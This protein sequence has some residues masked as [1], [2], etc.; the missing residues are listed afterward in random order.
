MSLYDNQHGDDKLGITGLG[1]KIG[2]LAKWQSGQATNEVT[3][4][5]IVTRCS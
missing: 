2:S 5:D 1:F 4:T 3:T